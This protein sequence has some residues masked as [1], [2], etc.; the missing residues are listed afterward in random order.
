MEDSRAVAG[1]VGG[2]EILTR[3]I[4]TPDEVIAIADAIT[5]EEL[6]ALAEELLISSQL[7]LAVVGPIADEPLEELLVI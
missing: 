7:R 5:A 2:Q 3:R 4:L 6:K 1:W